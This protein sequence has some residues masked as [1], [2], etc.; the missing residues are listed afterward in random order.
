MQGREVKHDA[1]CEAR[2]MPHQAHEWAPCGCADRAYA[3]DPFIDHGE[4]VRR[5]F[6]R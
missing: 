1:E 5:D 3:R 6:N 2:R 4:P